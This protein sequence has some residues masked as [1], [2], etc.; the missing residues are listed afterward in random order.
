M[1][2]PLLPNSLQTG[3][4]SWNWTELALFFIVHNMGCATG[5]MGCTTGNMDWATGNMDCAT[6]NMGCATK[7]RL[8]PE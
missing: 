4:F 7:N 6:G 8:D 2:V 3:N 5:N 1:N